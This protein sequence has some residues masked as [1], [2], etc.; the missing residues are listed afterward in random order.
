MQKVTQGQRHVFVGGSGTG[1][2][3]WTHTWTREGPWSTGEDTRK[4]ERNRP[5]ILEP[6]FFF[7]GL[8][9]WAKLQVKIKKTTPFVDGMAA[10]AKTMGGRDE[11]GHGFPTHQVTHVAEAGTGRAWTREDMSGGHL[12]MSWGTQE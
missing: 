3:E 7:G 5:L 1:F 10:A 2:T 6:F 12:E 11:T 9:F 4:R 8:F